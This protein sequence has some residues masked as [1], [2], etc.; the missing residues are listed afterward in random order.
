M[1]YTNLVLILLIFYLIY[2]F[3]ISEKFGCGRV[4]S[5]C[6]ANVECG[7]NDDCKHYNNNGRVNSRKSG[8]CQPTSTTKTGGRCCCGNWP[9]KDTYGNC[10]GNRYAGMC[11]KDRSGKD[12]G[13]CIGGDIS[14]C[15]ENS[16]GCHWTCENHCCVEKC[17]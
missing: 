8:H 9:D 4:G 3:K 16:L 1:N 10:L 14:K 17:V 12:I 2:R 6:R 15:G 11:G 13:L 7:C 5:K